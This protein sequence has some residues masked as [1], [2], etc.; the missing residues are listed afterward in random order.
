MENFISHAVYFLDFTREINLVNLRRPIDTNGEKFAWLHIQK[1]MFERGF[2]GFTFWYD[3]DKD[4]QRCLL[5]LKRAA[6]SPNLKSKF[7]DLSVLLTNWWKLKAAKLTHLPILIQFMPFL[8]DA[9]TPKLWMNKRKPLELRK[10][11]KKRQFNK[12]K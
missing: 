11:N 5:G 7:K 8:T 2:F 12:E 6:K 9:F 3:I 10:L 1:L 4:C